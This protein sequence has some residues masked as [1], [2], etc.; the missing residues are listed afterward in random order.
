MNRYAAMHSLCY[1]Q[2][3]RFARRWPGYTRVSKSLS[4]RLPHRRHQSK[5]GRN[6]LTFGRAIPLRGGQRIGRFVVLCQGYN[7]YRLAVKQYS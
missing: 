1:L 2:N 7:S 5:A 6:N 4:N 3:G